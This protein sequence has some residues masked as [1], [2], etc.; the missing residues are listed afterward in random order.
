MD[1]RSSDFGSYLPTVTERDIDI[2]LMEEFH[3]NKDFVAWFCSEIGLRNFSPDGAWH[4]VSTTDGESDLLLRV[5]RHGRRI[6]V[7]IE[8][9]IGAPE[10][11]RQGERYHI[12]GIKCRE[13]GKLDEYV[14]VMCAPQKYLE[15]LSPRSE[16]QHRFSYEQIASWFGRR[17]GPRAAWRHHIMREA[18]AQGRRG[19]TMAVNAANTA[20]HLAYWDHLQ[21][22]HP[23]FQMARPEKRGSKSNW[24]IF[25]GH[26]FPNGVK[27]YHKLI[28][29]VIE[30]GFPGRRVEDIRAAKPDWPHDITLVQKGKTAALSIHV[31]AIDM[32]LGFDAQ[33]PAVEEA[34]R[35]A[36]RLMCHAHLF[37]AQTSS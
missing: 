19:Y 9:K 11:D 25:E 18:I 8:N 4:S 23:Q 1:H 29:Q 33:L 24:I 28:Q 2:L 32:K 37:Q 21:K 5:A 15:A 7:L 17:R 10:Q 3:V 12:R 31:A 16:Y 22:R 6:G 13:Q 20:F 35:A 26:N 34:F 36:Y 27:I 30:I 14:T